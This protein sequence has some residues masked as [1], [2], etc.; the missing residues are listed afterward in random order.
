MLIQNA[1][2]ETPDSYI[3]FGSVSHGEF[4]K[5]IIDI[6][7]VNPHDYSKLSNGGKSKPVIKASKSK[8][9]KEN[10]VQKVI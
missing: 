6:N 8:A 4:K 1:A 9:S 7:S 10:K 3:H 5:R 2:K